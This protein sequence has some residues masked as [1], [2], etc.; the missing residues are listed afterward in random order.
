MIKFFRKIRQKLLSENKFNKYLIYAIGEIVLVVLGILI[1]LQVNNLN[2]ERQNNKKVS[3][4]INEI[5][6]NL[7]VDAELIDSI[8]SHNNTKIQ[9]L[10]KTIDFYY[11]MEGDMRYRDSIFFIASKGKIAS[12]IPFKTNITGL[13]AL[14]SSGELS[15][16]PNRI[17]IE[18]NN[19]YDRS[20][21]QNENSE[22]SKELTRTSVQDKFLKII[23]TR[24]YIELFT[25]LKIA[26][27]KVKNEKFIASEALTM[28][29]LFLSEIE[30]TRNKELKE[31]KI[32]GEELVKL[33]NSELNGK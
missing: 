17:R 28:D 6:N 33:I 24:E 21:E 23:V 18:L 3:G 10:I 12:F 19:Y 15:L 27:S 30:N 31:L 13:N 25:G 7:A 1:A 14:I 11:R 29:L 20:A 9:Q 16:I 32:I 4:Y 22:R 26:P 8:V 5:K 2:N